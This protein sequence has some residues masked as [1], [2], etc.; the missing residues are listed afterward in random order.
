MD[1]KLE[2]VEMIFLG[3]FRGQFYFALLNSNNIHLRAGSNYV[4]T[5]YEQSTGIND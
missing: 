2:K 3:T 1:A 4:T 5:R